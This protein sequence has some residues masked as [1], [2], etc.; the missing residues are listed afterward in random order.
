[1]KLKHAADRYSASEQQEVLS[2]IEK[3][4]QLNHKRNRDVEIGKARLI[5]TSPNGTRYALAV[6]NAGVLTAVTA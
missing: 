3:A 2:Q 1:M 5:V 4:D 6:S